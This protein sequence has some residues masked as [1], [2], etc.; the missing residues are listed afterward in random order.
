M[1]AA[2]SEAMSHIEDGEH[3]HHRY[4][5]RGQGRHEHPNRVHLWK[6]EM[7]VGREC[8]EV[9]EREIVMTNENKAVESIQTVDA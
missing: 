5:K 6:R 1:Q 9:P 3:Q 2:V 7:G 8:G 4:D